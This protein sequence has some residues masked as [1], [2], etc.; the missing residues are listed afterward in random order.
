MKIFYIFFFAFICTISNAQVTEVR[1]FDSSALIIGNTPDPSAFVSSHQLSKSGTN[2]IQAVSDTL[3]DA[4]DRKT[5]TAIYGITTNGQTLPLTGTN[6][7]YLFLGEKF[8]NSNNITIDGM[9]MSFMLKN[10]TADPDSMIVLIYNLDANLT[11][12]GTPIYS[13][14]FTTDLIDTNS[15]APIF[16]FIPVQSAQVTGSNGFVMYFQTYTG[17]TG[18]DFLAVFS[19]LQGD[20]AGEN[21]ACLLTVQ[22]S[23][24]VAAN[25]SALNLQMQDG[26]RPNFDIAMLPVVSSEGNGVNDPVLN[27]LTLHGITPN[28][29][30]EHTTVNFAIDQSSDVS[31]CLLSS[32]G[33][34]IMTKSMKLDAGEHQIPLD[35]NSLASGS[36]FVTIKTSKAK[37]TRLR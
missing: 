23:Q 36:Y 3:T 18:Y 15:V 7:M 8:P 37:L 14:K 2:K 19:T 28:P 4:W 31:I 17:V 11:P 21:R 16:T 20:G 10:I 29:G 27:G 5:G 35:I 13:S 33:R 9:L 26:N 32:D 22:N 24:L 1:H 12:S 30:N 25:F 6:N 34:E